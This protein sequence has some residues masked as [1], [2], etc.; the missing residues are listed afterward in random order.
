LQ[1][2]DKELFDPLLQHFPKAFHEPFYREYI[3]N[4]MEGLLK[5]QGF[6]KI[7]QGTGFTSKVCSAVATK[8]S[9]A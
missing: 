5:K 3:S 8:R 9:T 4:P 6:T 2:G 1:T 7:D